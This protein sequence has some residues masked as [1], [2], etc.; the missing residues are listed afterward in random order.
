MPT[1]DL[2][3]LSASEL[4]DLIVRAVKLRATLLPAQAADPPE[5]I[6]VA[7]DP[8]WRSFMMDQNTVLLLRHAG[9]GWV[10]FAFPAHERANLVALFLRHALNPVTSPPTAQST[11][12]EVPP[13]PASG[14]STVH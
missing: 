1:I 8:A 3:A 7:F 9:L 4:D 6:E 13:S 14:G 2:S 11:S 10:G 12:A 5:K